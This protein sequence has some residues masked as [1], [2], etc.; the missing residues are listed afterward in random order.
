M[1][2]LLCILALT[3]STLLASCEKNSSGLNETPPTVESFG[4]KL[5][6]NDTLGHPIRGIA[7]YGGNQ[8]PF[9]IQQSGDSGV[10]YEVFKVRAVA[11][12]QNPARSLFEDSVYL[13]C[14]ALPRPGLINPIGVTSSEGIVEC[15]NVARFAGL[16]NLPA[17]PLTSI[18][19]TPLGTFKVL[20]N[21]QFYLYDTAGH[22]HQTVYHTMTSGANCVQVTWK[23]SLSTTETNRRF[24]TDS[25]PRRIQHDTALG[26]PYANELLI[27][28]ANG[29]QQK[30]YLIQQ[31]L[32]QQPISYYELP[33]LPPG[34]IFDARFSTDRML[35]TYPDNPNMPGTYQIQIQSA[36]YPI[37]FGY[38]IITPSHRSFQVSDCIEYT[39]FLTTLLKDSGSV[40]IQNASIKCLQI[41]VG[42]PP[43]A[44][45]SWKLNQ[46]YP[47]P[48]DLSTCTI[49]NFDVKDTAYVTLK[50]CDL[51]N[52]EL[53][54]FEDHV[55]FIPG[56]YQFALC[57]AESLRI[58]CSTTR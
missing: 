12:Q 6:I 31:S 26:I 51:L 10:V 54:T 45:A 58:D 30:L 39:T 19:P 40:R 5:T 49:I 34:G 3:V 52:R 44:P 1:K 33:P 47:N 53:A 23:P 56:Y 25:R 9:P 14:A 17:I 21:A 46:N 8:L 57:Q 22:K 55:R 50:V 29:H 18:D 48:W 15:D 37:T 41:V 16:F 24:S 28:D 11:I 38:H 27:R 13:V 7:V 32:L 2:Y 36:S 4:L 35:E 43:E 42:S 20:S